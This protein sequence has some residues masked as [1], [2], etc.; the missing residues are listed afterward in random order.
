VHVWKKSP[1]EPAQTAQ[2]G[3]QQL[4][5]PV[6][7][8]RNFFTG[9]GGRMQNIFYRSPRISMSDADF[10]KLISAMAANAFASA[11]ITDFQFLFFIQ[12]PANQPK[13]A[14]ADQPQGQH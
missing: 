7:R 1:P 6:M 13:D 14:A 8:G 9:M 4:S 5:R 10:G 2:T 3:C 11:G 12:K